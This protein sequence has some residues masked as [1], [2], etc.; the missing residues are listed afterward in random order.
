MIAVARHSTCIGLG[1]SFFFLSTIPVLFIPFVSTRYT[2]VPLVGFVIVMTGVTR[3]AVAAARRKRLAAIVAGA[4][5]AA[6]FSLGVRV[7][8]G[9][10]KDMDRTGFQ[11]GVLLAEAETFADQIPIDRP[12]VW[13]RLER[14]NPLFH[15][16]AQGS[17]GVPKIYFQ[18]DLTPYGLADWAPLFSF[19]RF[20]KRGV[21]LTDLA[22]RSDLAGR[23]YAVV[24]HTAGRFLRLDPRASAP[25]E[26]ADIWRR[27][28]HPAG[29]IGLWHAHGESTDA[30]TN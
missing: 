23:P 28:G 26:E 30:P 24:A 11:Y 16:R 17:F 21:I 8:G 12:I 19:V 9:D 13:V 6:Y 20:S 3:E 14:R 4:C 27:Q 25:V 2:T 5:V 1:L 22:P 18:R 29:I 15:L 10:I 7:L